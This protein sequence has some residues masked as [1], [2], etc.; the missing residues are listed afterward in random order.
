[1]AINLRQK[2]FGADFVFVKKEK[3]NSLAAGWFA[4]TG[5]RTPNYIADAKGFNNT[6]A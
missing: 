4:L 3:L 1:M 2:I 5:G 6:D